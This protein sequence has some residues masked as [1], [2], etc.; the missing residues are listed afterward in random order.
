MLRRRSILFGLFVRQLQCIRQMNEHPHP[1]FVYY[2]S[3][4]YIKINWLLT[5]VYGT[6]SC[7]YTFI[8]LFNITQR[9]NNC[10]YL[11]NKS[12]LLGPLNEIHLSKQNRKNNFNK[13]DCRSRFP[14]ISQNQKM[15]LDIMNSNWLVRMVDCSYF[16]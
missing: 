7:I 12:L 16:S 10:F 9:K 1:F 15:K 14:E 6:S 5:F 11:N 4:I 3:V 8:I 2:N 13:F